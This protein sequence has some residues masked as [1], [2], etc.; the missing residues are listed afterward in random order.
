MAYTHIE[1]LPITEHPFE[2]SWGYQTTGYFAPTSRLGTPDDFKYFVDYCHQQGVGVIL[3]WAPAHFPKDAH[4]LAYFDGAALYEYEDPRRGEHPDW[5]TKIFD[6]G[7]NE[8]RNFLIASA[9]FWA[10]EY[11]IDG[12]RVDAVASMLYLDYS[13]EEGEWIPNQYGGQENLDAIAF[14]RQANDTLHERAPGVLTIA[15]ESSIWSKVTR[16]TRSGGL[17]FDFKWNMGWMNDTLT[18]FE[19]D[20]LFR[21]HYQHLITYSMSYAFSENFILPLSHDEV[22][23]LK[24]SLL[25]KMPGDLWQKFAHLRLLF[26]LMNAHPGK[27]LMFM[28]GEFGQWREWTETASLDWH[29]LERA[30]HRNLQRFVRD[31]N[32]L[33]RWEKALHEVDASWDGFQWVDFQ[34]VDHSIISFCAETQR[35]TAA[36][37]SS[38]TSRR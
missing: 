20:P 19:M 32:R 28:G 26:G 12:L 3:D 29:L 18:F 6:Y 4:G 38:A 9:L 36:F 34:D 7:R 14:L 33:Y 21:P 5:G 1:L 31:S 25:S 13:R 22:V 24:K 37:S 10:E 30:E 11:H 17:G 27:K 15:E 35:A 2:G 8:V 16:P 23:H